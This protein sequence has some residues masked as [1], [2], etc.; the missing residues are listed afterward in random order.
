MEE[1]KAANR[2]YNNNSTH[3]TLASENTGGGGGREQQSSA[4]VNSSQPPPAYNEVMRTLVR[5]QSCDTQ[6]DH[7]LSSNIDC[8]HICFDSGSGRFGNRRLRSNSF[9]DQSIDGTRIP[10]EHGHNQN[11][12]ANPRCEHQNLQ[13]MFPQEGSVISSMNLPPLVNINNFLA[14]H[15]LENF[16]P[17]STDFQVCP[18]YLAHSES[19]P[20]QPAVHQML[21]PPVSE[22]EQWNKLPT[23]EEYCAAPIQSTQPAKEDVLHNAAPEERDLQLTTTSD[24]AQTISTFETSSLRRPMEVGHTTSDENMPISFG[25]CREKMSLTPNVCPESSVVPPTEYPGSE[26]VNVAGNETGSP[27]NPLDTEQPEYQDRVR[28]SLVKLP[29]IQESDEEDQAA[30]SE[31]QDKHQV[32]TDTPRN[33][34]TTNMR[35]N[36]MRNEHDKDER[37]KYQVV[38]DTFSPCNA[39]GNKCSSNMRDNDT[40]NEHDKDHGRNLYQDQDTD[41]GSNR[42]KDL[43]SGFGQDEDH[44]SVSDSEKDKVDIHDLG[45][46]KE[47][48]KVI[49]PDKDHAGNLDQDKNPFSC[50]DQGKDCDL[51]PEKKQDDDLDLERGTKG[52][53][54]DK[55]HECVGLKNEN[56]YLRLEGA[57]EVVFNGN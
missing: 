36:D 16:T 29:S 38:T 4:A 56:D 51:G 55:E 46:D 30:H 39:L 11:F 19:W 13:Q 32:V 27:R 24:P 7:N 3:T 41:T 20:S 8:A 1:A 12:H 6:H 9:S 34:C 53:F 31:E 17:P 57:E 21:P 15:R 22:A 40:R 5:C 25:G 14:Q 35:D 42:H 48:A 18:S 52:T 26:N 37:D 45:Q 23:Y 43:S 50:S 54:P 28:H 44:V 2:A 33:Q 49:Y 47:H 10:N